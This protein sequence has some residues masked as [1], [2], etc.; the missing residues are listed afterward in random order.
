MKTGMA[1]NL[2]LGSQVLLLCSPPSSHALLLSSSRPQVI[3]MLKF[4]WIQFLAT[5]VAIWFF[6]HWLQ[7]FVFRYRIFDTRAVS[8]VQ[9][10]TQRN[11]DFPMKL[12]LKIQA[13]SDDVRPSKVVTRVSKHD[14]YI[15]AN[16]LCLSLSACVCA[17]WLQ[18][19][20]HL[21]P[22]LDFR[23]G[24]QQFSAFQKLTHSITY[25]AQELEAQMHGRKSL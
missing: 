11:T 23:L 25:G 4:A 2:I 18:R 22:W 8:D 21:Q 17:G 10:K 3:E 9:P 20:A 7:I 12:Q 16:L 6:F 15:F 13:S 5:F 1:Q 14:P 24:L 19:D